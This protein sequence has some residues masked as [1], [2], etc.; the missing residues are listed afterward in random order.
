MMIAVALK[1][2]HDDLPGACNFPSAK[3]YLRKEQPREKLTVAL[4][5][6]E[7]FIEPALIVFLGLMSIL[8][9]NDHV[10][11]LFRGEGQ[12]WPKEMGELWF[13]RQIIHI[14][15][16]RAFDPLAVWVRADRPCK[17]W[18]DHQK[19]RWVSVAGHVQASKDHDEGSDF[20]VR[21]RS[22]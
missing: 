12:T 13:A 17:N 16:S 6:I 20:V 4:K 2:A 18:N 7:V 1:P 5:F 22:F 11:Q 10:D 14:L 8:R 3:V 21:S 19:V 15:F 9:V